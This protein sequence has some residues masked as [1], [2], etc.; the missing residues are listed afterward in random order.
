MKVVFFSITGQTRKFVKKLGYEYIEISHTNPNITIE[1]DFIIVAPTYEKEATDIIE[2]L[3]ETGDNLSR[4]HGVVGGGNR[5]FAELYCFTAD[6]FSSDYNVPVLHKLEF[7][8]TQ[9]DVKAV[10]DAMRVIEQSL[11]KVV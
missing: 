6:D 4:C 11:N 10:L 8:G 1:D 3:I 5:N 2:D 7:Q 9:N